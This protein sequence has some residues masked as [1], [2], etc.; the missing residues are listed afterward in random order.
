MD[1]RT[2]VAGSAG[3][4]Q[5]PLDT[6]IEAPDHQYDHHL[7]DFAFMGGDKALN[8]QTKLASRGSTEAIVAM[9][10][11]R[12]GVQQSNAGKIASTA[13][14]KPGAQFITLQTNHGA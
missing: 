13:P 9:A 4:E 7:V 3:A 12:I 10:S 6:A 5:R 14:S 11:G 1:V 2:L 8:R